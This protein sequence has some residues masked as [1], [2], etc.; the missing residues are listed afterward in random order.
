MFGRPSSVSGI[1]P[2]T[3]LPELFPANPM[4]S[5]GQEQRDEA[6]S[7]RVL[8]VT[9]VEFYKELINL[10]KIRDSTM[11]ALPNAEAKLSQDP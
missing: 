4:E 10:S 3:P 1:D 5:D 2:Q 8:D 6:E 9:A 7:F 11:G